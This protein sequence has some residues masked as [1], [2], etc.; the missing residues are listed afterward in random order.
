LEEPAQDSLIILISD[1]PG[2]L[3]N[4]IRSRCRAVK[5]SPLKRAEL[6]ELLAGEHEINREEAH[7]LAYFSEGSLGRALKLHDAGIFERKNSSIDAFS[8]AGRRN[9]DG[10][11]LQK[12][13]E[14]RVLFNVL[15]AWFRDIY[16]KKGGGKDSEMIN[17]DRLAQISQEAGRM[18]F[19]QLNSVLDSLAQSLRRVEQNINLRLL[20]YQAG[21]DIWKE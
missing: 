17:I 4:T 5:F 9:F 16:L 20:L 13:E 19:E 14:A 6:E 15:A 1:K 3:F 2:L 18:T 11:S 8:S 12:R 10:I 7:F 21:L